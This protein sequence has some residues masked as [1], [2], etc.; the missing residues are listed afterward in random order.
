MNFLSGI[1][2]LRHAVT[3]SNCTK[4]TAYTGPELYFSLSVLLKYGT[5]YLSQLIS[6][7]Y[8]CLCTVSAV[9]IYLATCIRKFS[10]YYVYNVFMSLILLHFVGLLL[11]HSVPCCPVIL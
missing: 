1:P 9:W 10:L 2:L 7:R 8:P 5:N 11:V 6:D 4:E 3:L